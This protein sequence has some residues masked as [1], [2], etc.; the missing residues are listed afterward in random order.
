MIDL[1]LIREKPDEIQAGIESRGVSFDINKVLGLDQG[2]RKILKEVEGLR[3][4]K[5]FLSA[6]IG[7]SKGEEKDLEKEEVKQISGEIKK[8]DLKLKEYD[9]KLNDLLL[10]IP[11]RPHKTVPIGR[12][13]KDNKEIRKW[14]ILP[15][16][17][18]K[19]K[20]HYLLGENL[21]I[22]DFK[23]AAKLSGARF[24]VSKGL[25]AKLERALINFMLELQTKEHGYEEILLPVIV[26]EECMLGTGQLPKFK[27]DLF[28]LED[29]DLY[30]IPTAEVPL[31]NLHRNEVI[32]FQE[33]PKYYT[34]NTLC[35]RSEAGSYGKDTIG[36]IRQ[37][38]FNKVEL[39]KIV[40][41]ENSYA[42]LESLLENAEEVLKRLNLHY[43]VVCLCTGDSG[44]ASAKTYDV[45]VWM[46]GQE[47]YREISSCSNFEDFQAR[48]A[49]IR[50]KRNPDSKP[51]FVHTLNGSGLAVGRLLVALLENYQREDGSIVVP[52]ALRNYMGGL[53]VITGQS[54]N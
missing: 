47:R 46:P 11:N 40:K 48:R 38:Q 3:H 20:Q 13:E 19:P 1:K 26:K 16:F 7:K 39:V 30:L 43:R 34:A 53:E 18:F 2:K 33:L 27:N 50:F 6:E 32:P 8:L 49:G 41:P 44:F 51:E 10:V 17:S 42:E 9:C 45:E 36:L 52:E 4:R 24:S 15:E 12:D 22:L 35:F 37:H 54:A 5:K 28:K 23:R 31:T 21:G 29:T 14:G 25:G